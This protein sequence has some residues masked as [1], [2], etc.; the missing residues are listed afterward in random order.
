M[1]QIFKFCASKCHKNFK[2][3]CNPRRKRWTKAFRKSNAK[4][5]AVD[6]TFEFEKRRNMPV[7]YSRELW[8]K[9]LEA[10][11]RVE[12]IRQK[13]EAHYIMKRQTK[14]TL[15]ERE[16]DQKEVKRDLCLI[17]SAA[18]GMREKKKKKS[19]KV[20]VMKDDE[21]DQEM[22]EGVDSEQESDSDEEMMQSSDE[23]QAILNWSTGRLYDNILSHPW[24]VLYI[25][26]PTLT[27]QFVIYFYILY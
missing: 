6:A 26:S 7:K 11:K 10:M 2:H 1:S 21:L 12:L 19:A 25:I 18:A 15:F 5:L 24:L 16:R 17:R 8:N 14:A 3:K 4:D 22:N 13:R 27:I 20:V 23:E 9:S